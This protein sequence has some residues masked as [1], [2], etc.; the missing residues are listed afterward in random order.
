MLSW[1][2]GIGGSG[3]WANWVL[4]KVVWIDEV[5]KAHWILLGDDQRNCGEDGRA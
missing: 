3:D 4:V 1:S 2:L 5:T